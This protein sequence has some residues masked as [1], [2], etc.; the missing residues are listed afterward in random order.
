M[1]PCALHFIQRGVHSAQRVLVRVAIPAESDARADGNPHRHVRY[2][3]RAVVNLLN[4]LLV[5]K[6]RIRRVRFHVVV[7]MKRQLVGLLLKDLG[8]VVASD[9]RPLTGNGLIISL[10]NQTIGHIHAEGKQQ[11]NGDNQP[12]DEH[13]ADAALHLLF[14]T[15]SPLLP[16]NSDFLIVSFARKRGNRNRQFPSDFLNESVRKRFC[17]VVFLKIMRF[18]ILKSRRGSPRHTP[19]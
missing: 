10:M 2:E 9:E 17:L 7:D 4:L 19:A 14:Q 1:L 16:P 18:L 8:G 13:D 15:A 6:Q 3:D 12:V 5:G 11:H